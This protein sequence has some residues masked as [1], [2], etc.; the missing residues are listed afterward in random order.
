MA[1]GGKVKKGISRREFL[2]GLGAA[3]VGALA[4]GK[5]GV[6]TGA[7]DV[8]AED[9]ATIRQA[10][11]EAA[12]AAARRAQGTSGEPF[13]RVVENLLEDLNYWKDDPDMIEGVNQDIADFEYI[14]ESLDEGRLDDAV[15]RYDQLDTAAREMIYDID[16]DD[17]FWARR[18]LGR[19]GSDW[20]RLEW[21][22]LDV[23]EQE[24][25]LDEAE[26]AY[27]EGGQQAF[28]KY[29]D[30]IESQYGVEVYAE[31]IMDHFDFFDEEFAGGG[32]VKKGITRREFLT[33]LGAAGAGALAAGK[34]GVRTG[35][36]DVG[37]EDLATIRQALDEAAPAAARQLEP[38]ALGD[39]PDNIRDIV[40][41]EV[42]VHVDD[43]FDMIRE[44]PEWAVENA[45]AYREAETLAN[46]T[47]MSAELD[48]AQLYA[49]QDVVDYMAD[50]INA[51]NTPEQ[52]QS[53]NY[54][55]D[56][57][58]DSL[59]V[60]ARSMEE[61]RRIAELQEHPRFAEW[62]Q[63]LEASA[64]EDFGVATDTLDDI[65][66]EFEAEGLTFDHEQAFYVLA[67]NIDPRFRQ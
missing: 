28:D 10:L 1:G 3:G 48:E 58:K 17:Q 53:L 29:V 65:I 2:T 41:D 25:I 12:P 34:A 47:D 64:R 45:Q 4:A 14:A 62:T 46:I 63:R 38:F 8:G 60:S 40:M 30:Q 37:A 57:I 55:R 32:K 59:P 20:E 54:L 49:L 18:Q 39:I 52:Q 31:E 13:R 50:D 23:G 11:D 5:A 56:T 24:I 66:G 7:G 9:L 16:P 27:N 33:G 22:E 51:M 42:K 35:A 67:D 26:S 43:L 36:G 15:T 21:D 61:A 6:R 44:D 19:G